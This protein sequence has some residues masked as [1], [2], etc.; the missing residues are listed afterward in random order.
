MGKKE[1]V[2]STLKR[3]EYDNAL[4]NIHQTN[5]DEGFNAITMAHFAM[6][7]RVGSATLVARKSEFNELHKMLKRFPSISDHIKVRVV[8]EEDEDSIVINV[9]YS[10]IAPWYAKLLSALGFA[11]Y[12]TVLLHA[13]ID[14]V[15]VHSYIKGHKLFI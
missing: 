5:A 9:D 12:T 6:N 13:S 4:L 14:V 3:F 15:E 2:M 7:D 8:G 11:V 10:A 1:Y